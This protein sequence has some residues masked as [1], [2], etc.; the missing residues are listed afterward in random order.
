MLCQ[1]PSTADLLAAMPLPKGWSA[2]PETVELPLRSLLGWVAN[3]EGW[4]RT[5]AESLGA[6]GVFYSCSHTV[7][8]EYITRLCRDIE[9]RQLT[10]DDGSVLQD[11]INSFEAFELNTSEA[12]LRTFLK[13][14]KHHQQ[15][16]QSVCDRLSKRLLS[17]S[18]RKE[19]EDLRRSYQAKYSGLLAKRL[20]LMEQ[21]TTSR[22]VFT[23]AAEQERMS[24]SSPVST[25]SPRTPKRPQSS[26]DAAS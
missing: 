16:V 19:L 1:L 9:E 18:M 4:L 11:I 2:W 13:V 20:A 17:H 5:V 25:S 23:A 22:S 12:T 15:S 3:R 10:N 14:F 7:Q 26:E 24:L 6:E 21:S 8:N